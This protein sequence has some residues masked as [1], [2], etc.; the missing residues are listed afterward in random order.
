MKEREPRSNDE[1]AA[2]RVQLDS[3]STLPSL[4]SVLHDGR[5]LLQ[6][7]GYVGIILIYLEPL[8]E[9]E[10]ECGSEIYNDLIRT[11]CKEVLQLRSTIIRSGDLLCSV[12]PF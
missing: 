12:R 6:T 10:A 4:V 2:L 1:I 9:I 7:Y 5:V 11:V 3:A 8:A